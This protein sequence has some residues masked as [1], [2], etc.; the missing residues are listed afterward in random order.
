M[1]S[2]LPPLVSTLG[3]WSAT[4]SLTQPTRRA[5]CIQRC[6][7]CCIHNVTHTVNLR[8]NPAFCCARSCT[9]EL[10]RDTSPTAIAA[11]LLSSPR[12]T[13]SSA[14]DCRAHTQN[15][16]D[17]RQWACC[18]QCSDYAVLHSSNSSRQ[19]PSQQP[20]DCTATGSGG[21]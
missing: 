6:S 9:A 5:C 17:R 12:V 4:P 1:V 15:H 3:W 13:S 10:R 14:T 7:A 19:Q 21:S 18:K 2:T 16:I 8:V 11:W 20:H